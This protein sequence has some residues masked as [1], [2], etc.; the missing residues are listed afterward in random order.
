MSA[1]RQNVDK[2]IND[3]NETAARLHAGGGAD[4]SINQSESFLKWPKWDSDSNDH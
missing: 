3:Q 2:V 1:T 4:V